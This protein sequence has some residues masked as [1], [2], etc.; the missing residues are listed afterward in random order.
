MD[1]I[2]V[3]TDARARI[4]QRVKAS[5]GRGGFVAYPGPPANPLPEADAPVYRAWIDAEYR[6]LCEEK[7]IDPLI[8]ADGTYTEEAME[9][10]DAMTEGKVTD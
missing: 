9:M 3:L 5:K 10:W 4:K 8:H 6:R 2:A 1:D 7:G